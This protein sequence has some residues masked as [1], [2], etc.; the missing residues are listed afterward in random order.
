MMVPLLPRSGPMAD[1]ITL[2]TLLEKQKEMATL[3]AAMQSEPDPGRLQS[4]ADDLNARGA[5]LARLAEALAARHAAES[6]AG[7][8]EVLLTEAQRKRIL[9]ATGVSMNSIVIRD[10]SG[11]AT[12][13][14]TAMDPRV[15]EHWAL[16][17]AR[18]IQIARESDARLRAQLAEAI[19][20]VEGQGTEALRE[21]L[22]RLKQDP[23]FFG[24]LLNKK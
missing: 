5:E 11:I 6:S 12:R 8:T 19:A 10:T 17:E 9:D 16:Q 7:A 13:T 18:R 24:G 14:M 1:E 4:M 3:A 2:D 23:A 22:E 15:I 21:Q 20:A